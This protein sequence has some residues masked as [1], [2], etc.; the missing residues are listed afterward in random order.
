[1]ALIFLALAFSTDESLSDG[2]VDAI[3][4]S[5][6]SWKPAATDHDVHE[7]VLE[8]ASVFFEADAEADIVQSIR[9]LGEALN[10][11]QRRQ[12]LED[13]MRLAEADGLLLNSEQNVLSILASVWDIKATKDRLIEESTARFEGDPDWSVMHDIAL[14]YLIMAHGTD[15]SLSDIEIKTIVNRLGEWEPDLNET[16]I[17]SILRTTLE[18]YAQSPDE[19]DIKDSVLAIKSALPRAQRLVVLDDLVTI[20]KADGTVKE[21]ERTIVE[22]LSSAWNVDIRIAF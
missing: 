18:Y 19:N 1:M 21:G 17:R 9:S 2:E 6:K 20:A 16:Q 5:L 22:T 14:M 11:E 8:A 3:S 13:A 7:I 15:G 10:L 12:L 4:A